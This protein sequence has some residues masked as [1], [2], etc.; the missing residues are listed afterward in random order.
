[1]NMKDHIQCFYEKDGKWV[2]LGETTKHYFTLD[3]FTGCRIGLFI[4]STED[5]GGKVAFTEFKYH[6]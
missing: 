4:Y 2:Q 5:I 6:C 3:H 1:M